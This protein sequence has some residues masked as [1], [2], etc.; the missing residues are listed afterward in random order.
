MK[1]A[2]LILILAVAFLVAGCGTQTQQEQQEKTVEQQE[3]VKE[4]T[5][6]GKDLKDILAAQVKYTAEYD[7][8]AGGQTQEMTYIMDLPRFAMKN[9]MAEG[10]TWSIFKENEFIVCNNMQGSWQCMKVPVEQPET[11][12]TEKAIEEGTYK[13]VYK[14]TCSRAGQQGMKYE[15]SA[16]G[17]T[18]SVCY[19]SDGI[20]LEMSSEGF[21]MVAKSVSRNVDSSAFTPP[22]TPQDISAM[23]PEGFEMPAQ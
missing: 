23:L 4:Q 1:Y 10:E 19:T 15:F 7:L 9:K 5:T 3:Q 21:S 18:T 6:E 11:M 8:T 20:M 16:E 13:P 14:G 17:M 12:A 22:A 2:I